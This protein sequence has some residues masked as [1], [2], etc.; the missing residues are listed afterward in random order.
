M[1]KI[2]AVSCTFPRAD[3]MTSS[4]TQPLLSTQAGGWCRRILLIFFDSLMSC[5]LLLLPSPPAAPLPLRLC[6]CAPRFAPFMA[7]AASFCIPSAKLRCTRDINPAP[8]IR[9]GSTWCHVTRILLGFSINVRVLPGRE[10]YQLK[11]GRTW[12]SEAS[13]L[14][15]RGSWPPSAQLRC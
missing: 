14:E 1:R 13:E 5:S 9:S 11:G 3:F 12:N 8:K 15:L 7:L 10:L 6:A 2:C 4:G